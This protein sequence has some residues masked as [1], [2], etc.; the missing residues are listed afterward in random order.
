MKTLKSRI[1]KIRNFKNI[2]VS[3]KDN[4]YQEL[5]LNG[6]WNDKIIGNLIILIGEN[7]IGKSNILKALDIIKNKAIDTDNEKLKIS[8]KNNKPN[9]VSY[10]DSPLEIK[11][12][13]D[14]KYSYGVFFKNEKIS[15][16]NDFPNEK[17]N[18][19]IEMIKEDI[20]R[21]LDKY[22]NIAKDLESTDEQTKTLNSFIKKRD[23]LNNNK[24]FEELKEDYKKLKNQIE[25]FRRFCNNNYDLEEY[26]KNIL[27]Q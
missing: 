2:G 26:L 25:I 13:Y 3:E 4:E 18:E 20:K 1:L 22:I 15:I 14:K 10:L 21:L 24:G 8:F 16:I 27:Q 23:E 12:I 17:I 19:I 6:Y 11:I 7:N 9:N 5:Y